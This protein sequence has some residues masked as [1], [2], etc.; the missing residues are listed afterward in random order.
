[1][2]QH[3]RNSRPQGANTDDS[4]DHLSPSTLDGADAFVESILNRLEENGA[5]RD[6][7][8]TLLQWATIDRV[9]GR[10]AITSLANGV[11]RR[12]AF[13]TQLRDN[14][15]FLLQ[16][17]DLHAGYFPPWSVIEP[18][19]RAAGIECKATEV[20]PKDQF[21][22]HLSRG[23]EYIEAL[24]SF[25]KEEK[26]G[27]CG[28]F[29]EH[30]G[31]RLLVAYLNDRIGP[32]GKFWT[33]RDVWNLAVHVGLESPAEDDLKANPRKSSRTD[34]IELASRFSDSEDPGRIENLAILAG[35]L[36]LARRVLEEDD[37]TSLRYIHKA[38]AESR[39]D[40]K[41]AEWVREILKAPPPGKS[42]PQT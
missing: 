40:P 19:C 8:A 16:V 9:K 1:M 10:L 2:P 34:P 13:F 32:P 33:Y 24:L 41:Y 17:V 42:P 6:E 37:R 23:L 12:V 7:I 22:K 30:T 35:C 26:I 36:E 38:L 27:V 15:D 11:K 4:E 5:K 28:R 39:L 18:K 21:K 29:E 3:T 25:F 14:F 20:S 31:A